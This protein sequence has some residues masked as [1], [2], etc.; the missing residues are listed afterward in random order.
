MT[1][2]NTIIAGGST[3]V[4]P[5]FEKEIETYRSQATVPPIMYNAIGSSAALTG[6]RNHSYVFGMLS[7]PISDDNATKFW[8]KEKIARFVVSDDHLVFIYHLPNSL[9]LN[10]SQTIKDAGNVH[11]LNIGYYYSKTTTNEKKET[12]T[13]EQTM[14]KLYLHH[15][16]WGQVFANQFL[17]SSLSSKK[18]YLFTRETGSGTQSFFSKDVLHSTSFIANQTVSSN[19]EMLDDVVSTPNSFGYIDFAFV[20]DLIGQKKEN[21]NV[22]GLRLTKKQNALPFTFSTNHK[23]VNSNND[24]DINRP[25]VGLVNSKSPSFKNAIKFLVWIINPYPYDYFLAYDKWIDEKSSAFIINSGGNTPL[26]ENSLRF[27]TYNQSKNKNIVNFFKTYAQPLYKKKAIPGSDLSLTAPQDWSDYDFQE[28]ENR[29][30][31]LIS[32]LALKN[33][34]GDSFTVAVQEKDQSDFKE[35]LFNELIN[36]NPLLGDLTSHYSHQS[37]GNKNKQQFMQYLKIGEVNQTD[38]TIQYDI[39]INAEDVKSGLISYTKE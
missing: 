30:L 26:S 13:V 7:D 11:H 17:S 9:R 34:D 22:A 24:Y 31:F 3:S 27:Q 36:L 21:I 39:E 10:S 18:P 6:L 23:Q 15:Q 5:L 2:N 12:P 8:S 16:S 35:K 33:V 32:Q 4:A 28:H 29:I 25:F 1:P 14:Q 19:G 38:K 37:L 20:R